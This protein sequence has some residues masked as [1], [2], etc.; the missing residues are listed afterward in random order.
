M[1]F[2][3]KMAEGRP[4]FCTMTHS[5]KIALDFALYDYLTIY[6]T[7]ILILHSNVFNYLHIQIPFRLL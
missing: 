3:R 7:F 1:C 6:G 2:G 4:L 5:S